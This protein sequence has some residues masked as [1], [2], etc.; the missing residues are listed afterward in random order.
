M[1]QA[2]YSAIYELSH[3]NPGVGGTVEEIMQLAQDCTE[4]QVR[5]E[6]SDFMN[7]GLIVTTLDEN[8]YALPANQ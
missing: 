6:I 1:R 8:H 4:E 7:E 5:K 2:V 3:N